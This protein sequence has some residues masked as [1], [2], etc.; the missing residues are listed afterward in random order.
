M[1]YEQNKPSISYYVNLATYTTGY[2]GN[3]NFNPP[4]SDPIPKTIVSYT[5]NNYNS[6][7]LPVEKTSQDVRTYITYA[8]MASAYQ[9]PD[10]SVCSPS[11]CQQ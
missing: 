1:S 9:K 7:T 4:L 6:L 2:F 11:N 5:M 10:C 8:K 3:T